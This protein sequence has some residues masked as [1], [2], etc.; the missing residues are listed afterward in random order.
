MPERS[1]PLAVVLPEVGLPSETFIRW[2]VERLLPSATAV[3]ADPPPGGLSVQGETTW[4]LHDQPALVLEA[5]QGDPYPS[6]ERIAAVLGFLQRHH[7]T[8]VLIEYLDFA[9][10]WFNPLRRAGHR[11]WVRGHG[12]DLS[13][14]LRERQWV[15]AYRRLADADG[16]IVP[17]RHAHTTLA[18][19]GLPEA[20][21]HV[22]KSPVTLPPQPHR[23]GRGA[24]R[25]VA[26][27]RLVAKKAPLLMLGAFHHARRA[28]PRLTL[29]VV[30]DG[31]F[32]DDVHDFVSAH[33]LNDHIR[34]HGRLPHDQS[35]G[36][37]ERSDILI[38]H[39]V[40]AADG[41]TEGLPLAILEAMAAGLAVVSTNHAGIPEI[42]ADGSTGR[43]VAE[44]DVS[45]MAA[46]VAELAAD[47][48]VRARMGQAGRQAIMDEHTEEHATERLRQLLGLK[49]VAV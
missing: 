29:D 22:V 40:T 31:P 33:G 4:S 30:G 10:R 9:D 49:P 26:V 5:V 39:A 44:G 35:L 16:I 2:D 13:A 47:H 46:A 48:H 42:V 45:G 32:W 23:H 3:V 25:C 37:V 1:T 24:V 34:L 12:V 20:K 7:V 43:L 6:D 19:A 15:N 38:H 28:D 36:L 8:V 11:I 14:R 17:S 21:I 27:G 41:D 18:A